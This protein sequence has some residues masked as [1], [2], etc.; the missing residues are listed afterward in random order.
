MLALLGRS[1]GAI[2]SGIHFS[3]LM[4]F[5]FIVEL[6]RHDDDHEMNI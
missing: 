3:F 6:L 4:E 5:N 1:S 2:D